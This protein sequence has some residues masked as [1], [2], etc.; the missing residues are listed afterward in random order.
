MKVL[1]NNQP[2]VNHGRVLAALSS[3]VIALFPEKRRLQKI[4]RL[5]KRL[6][7]VRGDEI[8][9]YYG[10]DVTLLTAI[11]YPKEWFAKPRKLEFEGLLF[12]GATEPEKYMEK[13]YGNYMQLPPVE[14]QVVHHSYIKIDPYR[15]Y[16]EYEKYIENAWEAVRKLE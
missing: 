9:D 8:L 13:R 1:V 3:A 6:C 15:S 7:S 12:D 14:E 16:V 10:Q 5:E 4:Q 2:P 11:S